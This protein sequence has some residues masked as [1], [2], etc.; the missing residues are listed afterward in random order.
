MIVLIDNGSKRPAATKNLRRLAAEMSRRAG[1]HV[2]PVS[3]LHSSAIAPTDLDGQPAETIEAFLKRQVQQGERSF[4]I[5]PL[6]FGPS[7]AIEQSLPTILAD[8]EADYGPLDS[9]VAPVLCPLPKGEARLVDILEDQTREAMARHDLRPSQVILVDHGS[10]VPQVTAVRH[11]LAAGLSRRFA[12][13]LRVTEAVMERRQ[14]R[15]YDF[16]G[17][18]LEEALATATPLEVP[19]HPRAQPLG[20]DVQTDVVL[21]MQFISPGRH[22]GPGGDIGDI[23]ETAMGRYPGLRAV[24][25]RLISD[26]PLFTEILYDR[27]AKLG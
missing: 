15:Q 5:V 26:H 12:N 1:E 7:R 10:P 3:L 13:E 2:H 19:E 22:A 11:W 14:G 20:G 23:V 16:N 21:A 27:I 24:E 4:S 18:L 25:S 9:R 17:Q 6:F 8:I